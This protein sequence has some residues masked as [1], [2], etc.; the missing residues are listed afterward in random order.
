MITSNYGNKVKIAATNGN[1][2]CAD[3]VYYSTRL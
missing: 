2:K 1:G 3:L